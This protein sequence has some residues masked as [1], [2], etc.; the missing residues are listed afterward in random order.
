MTFSTTGG[1]AIRLAALLLAWLPAALTTAQ[2]QD[3]P[4][5]GVYFAE[6]ME[7]SPHFNA[8][9][10]AWW[11]GRL[12]IAN[13]E[14]AKLYAFTPPDKFDVLKEDGL[15]DPHGV[16]VDPQGR[17]LLPENEDHGP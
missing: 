14:P 8:K 13:R 17:H 10:M 12:V 4:V 7:A 9:G 16:A 1:Q 11:Q 2:P 5:S 3:K 15:T 6:K